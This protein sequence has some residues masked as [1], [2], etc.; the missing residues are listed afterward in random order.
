M[1][2]QPQSHTSTIGY[3]KWAFIVTAIGLALGLWLG[4][5]T[6]HT[7][8]GALKVFFIVCVLAV[9]EISLSFDN[10]IV[11]ANKLKDMTP[12]WQHRFLTWGIVIAVFGM[13]IVFPLA[14]VAIAAK[15]GPWEA[16]KL[17]AAL[18][19]DARNLSLGGGKVSL[20]FSVDA[21]GAVARLP[22][23]GALR[24]NRHD[25][26]QARVLAARIVEKTLTPICSVRCSERRVRGRGPITASSSAYFS[27]RPRLRPSTTLRRKIS[28]S[29]RL[30]KSRPPRRSSACSRARLSRWCPCSTSP[31]S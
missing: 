31:F 22:W 19:S 4:F 14:I 26:E 3:F 11:N 29:P 13:R 20:A 28:Y 5:A 23:Q 21:Q 30:S 2:T 25:A 6:E 9:L 7:V 18:R 1:S 16:L 17:A 24:L 10:A 12:E 15:I 27:H 8:A